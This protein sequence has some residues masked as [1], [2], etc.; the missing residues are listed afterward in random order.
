M[1]NPPWLV[2]IEEFAKSCCDQYPGDPGLWRNHVQLVRQ[3]A[4]NLA[5]IEGAN[6]LVLLGINNS[7]IMWPGL[8]PDKS[9]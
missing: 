7:E 2:Q 6:P 3:F 4:L 5:E 8:C 9:T 1:T